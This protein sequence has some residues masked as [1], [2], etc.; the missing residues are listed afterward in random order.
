MAKDA[1]L[2]FL[3]ADDG[4]TDSHEFTAV[5]GVDHT[6]LENVIKGLNGFEVVEANTLGSWIMLLCTMQSYA[7]A[8][9]LSCLT[10]VNGCIRFTQTSTKKKYYL[11]II[12]PS[13]FF[14]SRKA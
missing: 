7:L 8:K 3:Q 2:G 14:F 1:I 4:I 6:E 5:D 13:D 11:F 12:V 10:C 9:S